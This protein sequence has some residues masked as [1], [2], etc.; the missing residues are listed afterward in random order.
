MPPNAETV[1]SIIE[2]EWRMFE[3]VNAD[4]PRASCQK[5]RATF[6]SMRRAQFAAWNRKTVSSY[7]DDLH[8][9][10]AA[11][12]NLAREKYIHMMRSTSP[13]AYTRLEGDIRQP[14]GESVES[15][16]YICD[17]LI[18]QTEK[19]FAQFPHVAASGRPLRRSGDSGETTSIE[20]YQM[21]ELLTY[22]EKTL[23]LLKE[24]LDE[25]DGRGASL[26]RLMLE[27][28]L[29]NSG[30]ASLEEAEEQAAKNAGVAELQV[31]FSCP[32]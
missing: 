21:G 24:H 22:S 5:D 12:R 3:E 16:A 4:G 18:A 14:S 10:Q 9:A 2:I 19:I 13:Q 1:D 26:A 29:R 20:T 28:M 23:T 8:N 25:L 17:T 32:C 7:L 15:A 27:N 11:G 31:H 6:S 30:F